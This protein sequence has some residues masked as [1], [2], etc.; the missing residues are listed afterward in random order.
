MCIPAKV[1]AKNLPK[2]LKSRGQSVSVDT[3]ASCSLFTIKCAF[4]EG[5]DGGAQ[6]LNKFRWEQ[7]HRRAKYV[8][9][10]RARHSACDIFLDV[11]QEKHWVG[12]GP[13]MSEPLREPKHLAVRRSIVGK[14]RL[15]LADVDGQ[16]ASFAP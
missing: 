16:E 6:A 13:L 15:I 2:A 4:E 11:I 3:E 1:S 10:L 9:E 8:A 5:F 7:L 14:I 12:V